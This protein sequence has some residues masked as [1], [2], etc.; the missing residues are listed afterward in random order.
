MNQD[1]HAT[2]VPGLVTPLGGIGYSSFPDRG[3]VDRQSNL[4]GMTQLDVVY[5]QA[6]CQ[7]GIG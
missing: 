5:L 7:P 4:G 1:D 6:A 2:C 3:G